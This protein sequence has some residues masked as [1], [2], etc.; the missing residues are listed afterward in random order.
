MD[1]KIDIDR[2][3]QVAR[4]VKDFYRLSQLPAGFANHSGDAVDYL[5]SKNARQKKDLQA[6]SRL[7]AQGLKFAHSQT[8][9]E[10]IESC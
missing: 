7:I 6:R 9:R 10:S 4:A 5:C 2:A 8:A 3:H 1:K